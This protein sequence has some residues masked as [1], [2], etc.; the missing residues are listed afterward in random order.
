MVT[1]GEDSAE[2]AAG[3]GA[4]SFSFEQLATM[5]NKPAANKGDFH[6]MNF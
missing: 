2:G 1:A 5:T 4:A 3:A 6:F